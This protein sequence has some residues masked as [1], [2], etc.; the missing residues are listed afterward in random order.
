M[1]KTVEDIKIYH[2]YIDLIAYI[3]MITEKYPKNTKLGL[4]SKI[5]ETLYDGMKNIL[6]A[7][8]AFDKNDKLN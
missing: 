5:K 2:T 6:S 7:Y 4:V 3:E 1:K 8:K